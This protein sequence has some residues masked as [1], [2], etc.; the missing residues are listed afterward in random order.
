VTKPFRASFI[1]NRGDVFLLQAR[2]NNHPRQIQEQL[3]REA[4]RWYQ[5]ALKIHPQDATALNSLGAAFFGLKRY[6]EAAQAFAR[7]LEVLPTGECYLN[8]GSA[9]YES[10]EHSKAREA[11]EKGRNVKNMREF[12]KRLH[13]LDKQ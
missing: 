10:G 2:S 1:E 11:W 12:A 4:A 8:L 13:L 9:Y 6:Q 7:A 3:Y 5:Q